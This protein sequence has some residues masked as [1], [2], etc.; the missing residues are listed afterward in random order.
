MAL[1]CLRDLEVVEAADV[2]LA[3]VAD[4]HIETRLAALALLAKVHPDSGGGRARES[5]S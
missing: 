5:R 1:Y 4:E 3:A 2:A